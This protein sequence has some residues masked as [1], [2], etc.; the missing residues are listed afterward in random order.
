M[1]EA[2]EPMPKVATY[3]HHDNGQDLRRQ[4]RHS[5][6][7]DKQWRAYEARDHSAGPDRQES[8]EIAEHATGRPEDQNSVRRESASN[9][10]DLRGADREHVRETRGQSC[11]N[12]RQIADC[13]R[14]CDDKVATLLC[15]HQ[16]TER[17]GNEPGNS[18]DDVVTGVIHDG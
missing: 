6:D 10:D 17:T 15:A 4:W 9:R 8:H 11:R 7:L 1:A 16:T 3:C 13:G 18:V 2:E 14:P 12:E 5:H